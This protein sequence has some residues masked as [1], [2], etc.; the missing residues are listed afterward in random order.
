M[1]LVLDAGAL[2]AIERRDRNVIAR[3]VAAHEAVEPVRTSTA[4][5][6]QVW[7]DG[8]R[9]ATLARAL[10]GVE[11]VDIDFTQAREIG[12]LLRT[13]KSSDVVDAAIALIARSGDEI[14]T[15]DPSDIKAL[16][17]VRRVNVVSV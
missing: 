12:Q 14:L 2:I 7:R 10:R 6:A 11:E 3:L 8:T 17:Q 5:V 15:S 4:A 9:Q 16:V 1:A 13:T